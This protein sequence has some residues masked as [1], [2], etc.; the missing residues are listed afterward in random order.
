MFKLKGLQI[1]VR[2]GASCTTRQPAR[3]FTNTTHQ[4]IS[5]SSI[6][7]GDKA[8][9]NEPAAYPLV[10]IVSTVLCLGAYKLFYVD[11]INPDT[12]FSKSHRSTFDYLE[13]NKKVDEKWVNQWL[14]RGPNIERQ[15][16]PKGDAERVA[17][18]NQ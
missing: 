13:N 12:H 15:W 4:S 17:A 16:R 6:N 9:W 7:R 3:G 2:N 5:W 18:Q 8:S 11:A 1:A 10:A 14:H